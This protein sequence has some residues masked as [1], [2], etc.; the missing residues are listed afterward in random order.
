MKRVNSAELSIEMN[1]RHPAR[2]QPRV[3]DLAEKHGMLADCHLSNDLAIENGQ[4][5]DERGN[6]T[7]HLDPP[8]VVEPLRAFYL[9][10][11]KQLGQIRMFVRQDIYAHMLRCT[12]YA[13][14]PSIAVHTGD[15]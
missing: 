6:T 10:R 8:F 7:C 4:C 13:M 14:C 15:E 3:F 9:R 5:I 12:H 11:R 2:L 1:K